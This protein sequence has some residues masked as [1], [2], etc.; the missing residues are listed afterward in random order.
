MICLV[1]FVLYI[2]SIMIIILWFIQ[3][4][5]QVIYL[6]IHYTFLFEGESF[7]H[8]FKLI[9]FFLL[10]STFFYNFI[11]GNSDASSTY[12]V[13]RVFIDI[14]WLDMI[15][16]AINILRY[17][18]VWPRHFI[19]Y[20]MPACYNPMLGRFGYLW[21]LYPLATRANQRLFIICLSYC[22][23][24]CYSFT[25]GRSVSLRYFPFDY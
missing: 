19:K 10:T 8:S 25:F 1:I 4:N 14:F 11:K 24:T 13:S 16:L 5:S 22:T 21:S 12:F 9:K 23:P 6:I 18:H 7:T 15:D 3:Y 20:C 17:H 2:P